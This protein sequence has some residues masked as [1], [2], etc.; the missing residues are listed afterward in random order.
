MNAVRVQI[1]PQYMFDETSSKPIYDF[2]YAFHPLKLPT[3]QDVVRDIQENYL[4]SQLNASSTTSTDTT[5]ES[6]TIHLDNCQLLPFSSSQIL[7]DNDR[8]M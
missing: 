6:L 8:L 5:N 2:W 7:R 1:H 4:K 3:I